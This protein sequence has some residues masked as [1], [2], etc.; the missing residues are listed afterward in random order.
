MMHPSVATTIF[1]SFAN[2]SPGRE[3]DREE[4]NTQGER[5]GRDDD[6]AR[7][8]RR[9]EEDPAMPANVDA[10]YI[11]TT[12]VSSR[13]QSP[14]SLAPLADGSFIAP[15]H[16]RRR[17]RLHEF[18]ITTCGRIFILLFPVAAPAVRPMAKCKMAIPSRKGAS[19][20]NM[21]TLDP[22]P[23]TP[24]PPFLSVYLFPR[25]PPIPL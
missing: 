24:F 15:S 4:E 21:H 20:V 14:R 23:H 12:S 16:R 11:L 22:I 1:A 6:Q 10:H 19:H 25:A 2:A 13:R 8:R 17:R 7:G 18:T 9:E 3:A 5:R